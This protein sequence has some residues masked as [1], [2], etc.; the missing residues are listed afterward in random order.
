MIERL[1]NLRKNGASVTWRTAVAVAKAIIQVKDPES[2]LE[3]EESWARSLFKRIKFTN[4]AVTTGKLHMPECLVSEVKYSFTSEISNLVAQHNIPE[5]LIINF[6]QTPIMYSPASKYTMAPTGSRKV[7]ING[8]QDKRNLTAVVTVSMSGNFL[9]FQLI[10]QG[11]TNRSLPKSSYP[12]S[13]HVVANKNHWSTE[14]TMLQYADKIL[15]P[16][17]TSKREVYGKDMPCLII[18]DM[19]KAHLTASFTQKMT[20]LNALVVKIP[21][22]MTDHLQPLDLSVNKSLKNYVANKF[23]GWYSA[24]V[25]DIDGGTPEAYNAIS[26]L[27]KSCVEMRE[28]SCQWLVAAYEHYQLPQQIDIITNGFKAAGITEQIGKG[29]VSDDPFEDIE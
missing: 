21:A 18:F 5:D 29:P 14:D 27:L 19:F 7:S 23:D 24:K 16:Y 25:S 12:A 20:E 13:F 6:D 1:H 26:Q 15:K 10:Y 28:L 3:V 9:P 4:R 11:L 2:S 22:N 8:S 17:V